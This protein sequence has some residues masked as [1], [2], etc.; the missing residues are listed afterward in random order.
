MQ[1][2]SRSC[3]RSRGDYAPYMLKTD[4]SPSLQSVTIAR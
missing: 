3:Y 4:G 2:G 1:L